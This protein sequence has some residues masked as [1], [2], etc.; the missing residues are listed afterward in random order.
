MTS[1]WTVIDCLFFATHI[2]YNSCSTLV[3]AIKYRNV[4]LLLR[5]LF[6]LVSSYR[7]VCVGHLIEKN[8]FLFKFSKELIGHGLGVLTR[9]TLYLLFDHCFQKPLSND[10]VLVLVLVFLHFRIF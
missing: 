9:T 10:S 7:T 4:K 5:V 6:D 1:L 3:I 2:F 8:I